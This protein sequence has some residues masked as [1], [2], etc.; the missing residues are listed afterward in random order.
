MHARSRLLAAIMVGAMLLGVAGCTGGGGAG[1]K[2]GATGGG[3]ASGT[4]T[5]AEW[6]PVTLDDDAGRSVTIT[7]LPMRIVSLAPGNTEIVAALGLTS[8]LVGVTTYDDYPPEV[9]SLPKV[10]DFV[11]PNLEAIAALKPDLVLVTTGVQADAVAKLEKLGAKVVAVDPASIDRLYVDI[12]EVGRV[13]GE[14]EKASAIVTDMKARI[15]EV[16]AKI[17]GRK[18]VTAFIEIA[19][20]PLYTTGP[21]TLLSDVLTQ[22]GGRNIVTKPA[23]VA[24]SL[25]ELLKNDPAV[26]LATKGSMNDPLDV[27]KRPGYEKL[28]AV[29]NG[30]VFALTDNLVSRPGP[31]VAQGVKEIASRLYPDAFK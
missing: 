6:K 10:G 27:A 9:K 14:P 30:R 24:Y 26:Y 1:T 2:T 13:V 12:E 22:A 21:G 29:R 15:A 3:S 20:N 16:R 28:S 25:E 8:R 7:K 18:P 11:T 4:S 19:Q 31:R 17:A 5:S 23:Y